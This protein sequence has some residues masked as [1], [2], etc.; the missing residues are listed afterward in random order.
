MNTPVFGKHGNILHMP[1]KGERLVRPWPNAVSRPDINYK[2]TGYFSR[3]FLYE[4][5]HLRACVN[6]VNRIG[7]DFF[8]FVAETCLPLYCIHHRLSVA[9]FFCCCC[10]FCLFVF[11]FALLLYDKYLPVVVFLIKSLHQYFFLPPSHILTS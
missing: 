5:K 1:S 2:V 3:Y 7:E 4:F 9:L 10:C 8:K 6:T 11:S